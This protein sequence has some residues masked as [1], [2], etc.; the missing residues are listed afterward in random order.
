[1][2]YLTLYAFSSE[3]WNRPEKE[4]SSL[5]TLLERFLDQKSDEMMQ[6]DESDLDNSWRSI[7]SRSRGRRN[8]KD[9]N[10]K[11][12]STYNNNSSIRRILISNNSCSN[13]NNIRRILTNNSNSNIR[14]IQINN[15]NSSNNSSHRR[16]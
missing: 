1:M 5:M 6:Q 10:I 2:K 14:E 13:N 3:N 15:R 7:G 12:I 4:I 11:R 9:N 16:I 8:N